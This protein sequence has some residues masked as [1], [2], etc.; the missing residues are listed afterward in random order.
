MGK[1]DSIVNMWINTRRELALTE[2]F[3]I[4]SS[5]HSVSLGLKTSTDIALYSE[6]SDE[7][8]LL[9]PG[10]ILAAVS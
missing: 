7:Q 4:L 9:A 6:P 1:V 3:S 5:S 10:H 8:T 2:L